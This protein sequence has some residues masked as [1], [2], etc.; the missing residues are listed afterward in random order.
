VITHRIGLAGVQESA[1]HAHMRRAIATTCICW[2]AT[3]GAPAPSNTIPL[4]FGMSPAQVETA[5]G[6]P[7]HYLSGR[8]GSKIYVAAGFAP[9]HGAYAVDTGLALQFR[10]GRLTGWKQDWQLRRPGPFI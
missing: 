1:E 10:R 4:A 3:C 8:G 6:V 5:L 7:L 2:L 9:I